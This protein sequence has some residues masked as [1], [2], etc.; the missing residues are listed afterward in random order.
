MQVTAE[1]ESNITIILRTE[2]LNSHETEKENSVTDYT[3]LEVIVRVWELGEIPVG[4][5]CEVCPPYTY[6]LDP[7]Q[8]K[9]KECPEGATCLGNWTMVPESGY[10]RSNMYSDIFW[11]WPNT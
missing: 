2:S 8:V 7:H 5:A 9:C 10:W 4:N 1:P 3:N 11:K 6:S